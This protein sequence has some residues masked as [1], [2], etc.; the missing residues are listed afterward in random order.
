M[1]PNSNE[2]I[3]QCNLTIIVV[4]LALMA[5]TLLSLIGEQNAP[6]VILIRD[7]AFAGMDRYV[8]ITTVEMEQKRRLDHLLMALNLPTN[9]YQKIVVRADDLLDVR[10]KLETL[11]T[12]NP[13]D[14]YYI[15]LTGGTKMMSIGV[16]AFFSQAQIK[17]K[18]FYIPVGQQVFW[19]IHPSTEYKMRLLK[20]SIDLSTYLT[21]YGVDLSETDLQAGSTFSEGYTAELFRLFLDKKRQ[22]T[23]DQQTFGWYIYN[24]RG[25]HNKNRNAPIKLTAI[26]QLESFLKEINFQLLD[27]KQLSPVEIKYLIG[28]WF[29]EWTYH[30]I[31]KQLNLPDKAIAHNVMIQGMQGDKSV[32]KNEL[33]V[34]FMFQNTLYLVECKLGLGDKYEKIKKSL[35][36]NAYRL[37][38]IKKALG[39]LVPTGLV[40]LSDKTSNKGRKVKNYVER[41]KTLRITLLDFQDLQAAPDSWVLK[42]VAVN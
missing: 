35:D 17:A 9:R 14:Q 37:G 42:L 11:Y 1:K 8:F 16:F 28:G 15:N 41:I 3:Q 25:K 20:A 30:Q 29:E 24:L 32:G 13:H 26:A 4:F 22:Y 40:T 21:C 39:I 2:T 23:E 38:T 31:K 5:N 10:E 18:I 6:N 36:N 34:M 7:K 12:D 27:D 19:Q 33:D